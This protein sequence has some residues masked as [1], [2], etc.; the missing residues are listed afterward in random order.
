VTSL[1]PSSATPTARSPRRT[2][3]A[4]WGTL[5]VRGTPTLSIPLYSLP[6]LPALPSPFA[7]VLPY[8]LTSELYVLQNTWFVCV[9]W[10]R[11]NISHRHGMHAAV[12]RWQTLAL[13][14]KYSNDSFH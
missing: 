10:H 3:N 5:T 1:A 7:V 4:F 12:Y 11:L 8:Y 13:T 6:L 9:R 2:C 14:V